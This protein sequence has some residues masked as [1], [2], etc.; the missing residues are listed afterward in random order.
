VVPRDE[1]VLS[2]IGFDTDPLDSDPLEL[3]DSDE[4]DDSDKPDDPLEL[5]DSDKPDESDELDD[6]DFKISQD[7]SFPAEDQEHARNELRKLVRLFQIG[8]IDKRQFDEAKEKL[9]L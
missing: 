5:D 8:S 9:L 2:K 6:A 4:P 1:I 7:L 3:D